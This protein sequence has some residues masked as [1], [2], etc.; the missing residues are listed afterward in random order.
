[1]MNPIFR[2]CR[3]LIGQ[4]DGLYHEAALKL[5]LTDSEL[6]IL[7]V[8]CVHGPGCLQSTLYKETGMTKSTVNS[9]VK[10]MEREGLLC[11]KPGEKR[12]TCVY[13]TE[14]GEALMEQTVCRLIE[15]ENNIYD[16]WSPEEQQTFL[17]LNRDYTEQFRKI[18]EIL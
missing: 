6:N 3:E 7:Y 16:A 13:A 10:K 12:N 11:L 2:E 4:I 18:L 8:L 1:M 9:A 14:T 15:L 5:N 17:R